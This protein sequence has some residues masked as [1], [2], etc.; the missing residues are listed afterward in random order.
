MSKHNEY[1]KNLLALHELT[2]PT[3][4][5]ER[6]AA[7]KEAKIKLDRATEI[8]LIKAKACFEEDVRRAERNWM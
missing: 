8:V 4:I 6:E 7:L 3:D 5:A 2:D 1:P